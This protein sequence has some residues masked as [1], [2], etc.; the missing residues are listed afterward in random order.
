MSQ[1]T[2][3]K[4]S[5]DAYKPHRSNTHVV[6]YDSD[7]SSD[8]DKEVYTAEFVWPSAA[9][10]SSCASIKPVQKNRKEEMKFTFDVSKCYRIFDELLRLG[11]IKITHVIPPLEELKRRAYCKFHNSHSHVTNDCNVFRRQVQSAMNEGRLIFPEL[12]IDKISFPVHTN[13]HTIG[14]NN[15][16]VLLRPKQAEGAKGKNVVIGETRPKNVD[17]KI[18]AREVV[19][20]KAP[21]SKEL[22]KITVKGHVPMGQESFAAASRPVVQDRPVR[23]DSPTGQ[24]DQPQGRPRTFK[25]KRSEVGT[26]KR[27]VP[28]VQVRFAN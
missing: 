12:K 2:K 21:D 13:T 22:I 19:L 24:T 7:S 28:N 14:L 27:N 17:D 9:K 23:S 10:P 18:L 8:E 6:E 15:A 25:P 20:E 16:K 26:W 3:F 5:K 4:N 1:E 11:H